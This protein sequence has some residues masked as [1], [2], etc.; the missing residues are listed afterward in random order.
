MTSQTRRLSERAG[1]AFLVVVGMV[2][3]GLTLVAAATPL[4]IALCGPVLILGGLYG[5]F[6]PSRS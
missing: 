1:A 5:L 4:P 6:R 3:V 2:I